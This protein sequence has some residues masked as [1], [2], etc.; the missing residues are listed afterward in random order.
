MKPNKCHFD[1]TS[2][3]EHRSA[4]HAHTPTHISPSFSHTPTYIYTHMY[5]MFMCSRA[6]FSSGNEYCAGEHKH[7]QKCHFDV[8]C[9][10]STALLGA[11]T[12]THLSL[13]HTHVHI[14]LSHTP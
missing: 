6:M 4:G 11:H 13:T 8:T 2:P 14:A 7:S 5:L 9:F 12:N 3:S 10:L 1:I